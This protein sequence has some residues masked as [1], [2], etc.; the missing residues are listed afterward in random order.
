MWSAVRSRQGLIE[1]RFME[2]I[3]ICRSSLFPH[4]PISGM[5][6]MVEIAY[7]MFESWLTPC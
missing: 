3:L 5:M 4:S 7:Y 6:N 2:P 1:L